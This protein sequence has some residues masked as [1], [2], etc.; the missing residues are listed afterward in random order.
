MIR[1]AAVA[2]SVVAVIACQV[3]A[4]RTPQALTQ[5]PPVAREFRG[6]WVTPLEDAGMRDWPSAPGL[7]P[8][9]QRA[10]LRALL[11][12]AQAIGLNAILLHVRIA[13]DA[14]YPTRFAPWS[15]YLTGKSGQA[16]KPAYDPLAYAVAEAHARGMQLHAWFNPFRAVYPGGTHGAVAASHVTRKHPSWIRHYGRQSWIDP[17]IPEARAM[18][19]AT[20]MDVV[21][22]YD[23]DGVHLD[24]YFYPYQETHIVTERLHGRRVHVRRVIEFPDDASW[25]RYG[26]RR[27]FTSRSDW[28]RANIDDFVHALYDSVKHAKPAVAVGI[29]PF[30][31]WRPGS[32]PGVSGLD[33]YAELFADSRT[34]LAHGWV[35][36]LAPQLYWPIDGA[37]HRFTALDAWWHAQ[38]PLGRHVWPGLYTSLAVNGSDGWDAQEI[39]AQIES[40]R[41][42]SREANDAPGHVHFRMAALMQ[43]NGAE[44]SLLADG[45]YAEPAIPPAYPWLGATPPATPTFR[46]LT[47]GDLDVALAPGGAASVR[48]WLIQARDGSGRWV[49]WVRGRA[50]NT[51]SASE[52]PSG[53]EHPSEVAVT[54]IGATGMA[55]APLLFAP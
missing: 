55:S 8:D 9:S 7:S 43:R 23:I 20:I 10:E 38:N 3:A 54:A 27:G 37:E 24:D 46:R 45:V 22:R 14:M 51:L 17:G 41:A 47:A 29:S 34:W 32:P 21:R 44:G 40:L 42:A 18:V 52:M 48:F 39:P 12:R 31:I 1:R 19:L 30:G 26:K 4:S 11:D 35:D 2:A 53:W 5:P 16:P 28:R 50:D 49:S 6:V 13:G 15:A 33:A 36:Y 25:K